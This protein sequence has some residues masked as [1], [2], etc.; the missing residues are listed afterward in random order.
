MKK[1]IVSEYLY[2]L[3]KAELKKDFLKFL[4]FTGTAGK[5][6]SRQFVF[7]L[8]KNFHFDAESQPQG[9][10]NKIG[11][12]LSALSF[13]K[14]SFKKFSYWQKFYK[15]KI[16]KK[17]FILIELGAD[18][19]NDINWFLKKWK[20]FAVFL[21]ALSEEPWIRDIKE[22][23]EEKI[24][25]L[26]SVFSEGFIFFNDDCQIINNLI[27]KNQFPVKPIGISIYKQSD[28][29][30]KGWTKNLYNLPPK[31][32]FQNKEKLT[33]NVFGEEIFFEFPF[34]IFEPQIYAICFGIA[35]LKKILENK[36]RNIRLKEILAKNL[37]FPAHRLEV[38]RAKNGALIIDDSYKCIPYCLNYCVEMAK[39]I[40]A[41]KKILF[42]ADF[43]PMPPNPENFL[44]YFSSKFKIFEKIYFWG[45]EK[46]YSFLKGKGL[47]VF[48]IKKENLSEIVN[49]IIALTS[50]NDLLLLKGTQNSPI[51]NLKTH[52]L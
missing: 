37:S 18:F 10:T 12:I 52:L 45:K 49:S 15:A 28:V 29:F 19:R 43:Y 38:S 31:E 14:F 4:V 7:Q 5:T 25:L 24:K 39:K 8:L 2:I 48:K 47:P 51:F 20:P 17:K 42:L 35:F 41:N 34:C 30:V 13:E 36:I 44:E 6:I 26:H 3:K 27:K 33:L 11:I 23:V 50:N 9:Y 21:T 22:I 40:K 1:E 46:N 32:I 16:N